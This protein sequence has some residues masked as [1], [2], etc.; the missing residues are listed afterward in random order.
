M[1]CS[2]LMTCQK[3]VACAAYNTRISARV[4][5]RLSLENKIRSNLHWQ[6]PD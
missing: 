2:A 5:E 4:C 1:N 6:T 3:S